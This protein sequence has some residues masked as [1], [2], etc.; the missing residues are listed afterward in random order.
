MSFEILPTRTAGSTR[1]PIVV[2]VKSGGAAYNLTGDSATL[3]IRPEGGG[4]PIVTGFAHTNTPGASGTFEWQLLPAHVT[5]P[6]R[7]RGIATMTIGGE[8]E[9]FPFFVPISSPRT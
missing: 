9:V 8:S 4:A 6:G 2:R 5:R 3:E 1:G 7:H